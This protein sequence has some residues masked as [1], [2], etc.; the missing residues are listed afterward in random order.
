MTDPNIEALA[1]RLTDAQRK[2]I[3]DASWIYPGGQEPICIV[4]YTE[5]WAEPVAQFFTLRSDRLT[6]LGLQVRAH[7]ERIKND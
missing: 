5:P 7:L 6:P 2:A 3:L 1:E 4:Q